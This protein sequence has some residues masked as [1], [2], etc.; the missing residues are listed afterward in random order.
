LCPAGRVTL[1]SAKDHPL[2]FAEVFGQS[3]HVPAWRR[4]GPLKGEPEEGGKPHPAVY[5][6]MLTRMQID[7]GH[8]VMAGGNPDKNVAEPSR[9]GGTFLLGDEVWVCTSGRDSQSTG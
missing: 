2:E 8:V 3:G 5:D 1:F 6:M 4:F 7:R 9:T